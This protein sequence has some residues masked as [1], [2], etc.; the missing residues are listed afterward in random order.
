MTMIPL[1]FVKY[2]PYSTD[3]S[4]FI[5][6]NEETSSWTSIFDEEIDDA[7]LNFLDNVSE[8]D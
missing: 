8:Y 2:P 7:V 5:I 1:K 3:S 6:K 4:L